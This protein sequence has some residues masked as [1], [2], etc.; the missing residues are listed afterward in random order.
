MLSSHPP[1]SEAET[2]YSYRR[3]GPKLYGSC[4]KHPPWQDR[5]PSPSQ[6]PGH[7]LGHILPRDARVR[8]ERDRDM[9]ATHTEAGPAIL[10][11]VENELTWFVPVL[12]PRGNNPFPALC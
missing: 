3:L 7:R 2:H 6:H 9:A 12:S 1:I 11:D 8:Q 4:H 10:Q 5:G